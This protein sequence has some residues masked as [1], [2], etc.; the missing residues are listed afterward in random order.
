[1]EESPCPRC[2]VLAQEFVNIDGTLIA[3]LRESG[4]N[5]SLPPQVCEKCYNEVAGS[6][7]RGGLLHAREKAKENRRM[8]MWKSRVALVKKARNSM[9]EKAFA[10]AAVTYEK[11]LKVLEFVL[12]VKSGEL[13]PNLFKDQAKTS[14]L[15]IV[16]STYWDLF[17]IYDTSPRY[18][19]KQAS[20]GKKLALFVRY[21]PI[22]PDIIRKAEAF[23]RTAKNPDNV[24]SFLK[25]AAESKGR[26]FIATAAFQYES[27]EVQ[28]LI[29]F[30]DNYLIKSSIGR[31]FIN[32]YYRTSPAVAHLIDRFPTTRPPIQKAVSFL[33][34]HLRDWERP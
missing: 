13:T 20:S 9:T 23:Q 18:K 24:K 33:A 29:K 12:D 14:E 25:E 11:Y 30:R 8:N 17:R 7:G 3:K 28:D 34:K 10:E 5:E 16:A 1:M 31:L 22:Y 32:T 21:T 6:I 2:G 26:C 15:T 19:E 27:Q 4:N